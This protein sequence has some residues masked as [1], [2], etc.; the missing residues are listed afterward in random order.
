MPLDFG[1][2]LNGIIQVA[3]VVEDIRQS[4]HHWLKTLHVGPWFLQERWAPAEATYRQQP[5]TAE[6]AAALA[7]SGHTLIEFIQPLDDRPSV[8]REV[9]EQ[10]GY[11]FHHIACSSEDYHADVRRYEELGFP[12]A[13]QTRVPTGSLVGYMDTRSVLPGFTEL[14]Q[15][16]VA[17]ERFFTGIHKAALGWDG[18]DPLRSFG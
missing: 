12:L 10:R 4:I 8:Y 3:F 2:P 18:T 16:T 14:I 6:I 17:N 5:S 15:S 9:I 7:F 11:G 1:Q 13:F